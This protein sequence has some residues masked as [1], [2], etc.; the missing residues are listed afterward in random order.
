MIDPVPTP[1]TGI[2]ATVQRGIDRLR[3]MKVQ[4]IPFDAVPIE[5]HCQGARY[6]SGKHLGLCFS[7]AHWG[8]ADG[9][10]QPRVT[11]GERAGCE[12]HMPVHG[13]V[14]A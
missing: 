12:D 4:R 5:G 1:E 13:G 2:E 14:A 3:T 10:M 9:K 6:K 11:F 7:C 8:L